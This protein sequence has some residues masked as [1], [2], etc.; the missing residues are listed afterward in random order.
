MRAC[1]QRRRGSRG[2]S[3]HA[4]RRP[5]RL[6]GCCE[7]S[8]Q[9]RKLPATLPRRA[10]DFRFS[11]RQHGVFACSPCSAP[12]GCPTTRSS[13]CGPSTTSCRVM[14][15]SPILVSEPRDSPAPCGSCCC[16]CRMPSH[17][18]TREPYFTV[19]VASVALS[20]TSVTLLL[21]AGV[22]SA[23]RRVFPVVVLTF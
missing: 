9:H 1:A 10:Q 19:I 18:V 21:R 5:G 8:P 20:M 22:R 14:D 16:Q 23:G 3:N 4:Q 7:R 12:R 6:C 15:S 13:H 2:S 17:A 11:Q